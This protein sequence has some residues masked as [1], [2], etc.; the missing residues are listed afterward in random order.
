MDEKKAIKISNKYELYI[1]FKDPEGVEPKD[2]KFKPRE[3]ALIDCLLKH[4][5]VPSLVYKE[6]KI[7][8]HHISAFQKRPSVVLFMNEYF[9]DMM[10]KRKV[11]EQVIE[12][13]KS[14][15]S[16][17]MNRLKETEAWRE[18]AKMPTETEEQ[19]NEKQKVISTLVNVVNYQVVGSDGKMKNKHFVVKPLHEKDHITFSQTSMGYD[20]NIKKL[21]YL[22]GEHERE[23]RDQTI[24]QTLVEKLDKIS[25]HEP[26]N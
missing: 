17:M 21:K 24:E 10:K 13:N 8:V 16:H 22:E 15:V 20:T 12:Y 3:L 7:S 6:T 1:D 26:S 4:R 23:R 18:A 11:Y 14:L 19:I 2:V 25:D 9:L 5:C